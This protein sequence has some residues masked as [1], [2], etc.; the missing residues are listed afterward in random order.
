ML[1]KLWPIISFQ[2]NQLLNNSIHWE[3]T[4][5][6]LQA[7]CLP[8]EIVIATIMLHKSSK[9]IVRLLTLI[10]SPY[11]FIFCLDNVIQTSIELIKQFFHIKKAKISYINNYRCRLR[12]RPSASRKYTSLSRTLTVLPRASSERHRSLYIGI[13]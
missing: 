10:S 8:E 6:I 9:A 3:K 13:K 4:E 2:F 5:Q 12:R 11:F 7:Y 1:T